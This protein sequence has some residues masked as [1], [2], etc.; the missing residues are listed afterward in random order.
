MMI[1][2]AFS[3]PAS[4]GGERRLPACRSRQ[5]AA[6]SSR[7]ARGYQTHRLSSV[8]SAIPASHG[9][10]VIYSN[11]SWRSLSDRIIRSNDSDSHTGSLTFSILL[12]R[13]AVNDLMLCRILE[14]EKKIEFPDSF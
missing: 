2:G 10:H 4:S 5:P 13:F 8:G 7:L 6:H 1:C 9:F 3:F 14:S 11:F 12:I